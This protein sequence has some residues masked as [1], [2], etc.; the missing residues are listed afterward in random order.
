MGE[1]G[2]WGWIVL[3]GAVILAFAA[4]QYLDRTRTYRPLPPERAMEVTGRDTWPCPSCGTQNRPTECR[5]KTRQ[6]RG[7]CSFCGKAWEGQY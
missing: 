7:V 6:V 5:E 2:D 1:T 3:A 4:R